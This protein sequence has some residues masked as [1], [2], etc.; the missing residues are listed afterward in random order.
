MLAVR[1]DELD[2]EFGQLRVK[3]GGGDNGH[4][5]LRSIRR[6]IGSGEFFRVRFG[7]GRPPGRQEPVFLSSTTH[8]SPMRPRNLQLRLKHY[9]SIAGLDPGL[10]PHKLLHSYATHL[11]DGG[12][13]L[14]SV[15]TM[16][17]HADI[18]IAARQIESMRGLGRKQMAARVA[19]LSGASLHRV[20]QRRADAAKAR[21]RRDVIHH[22]LAVILD[23]P[24]R[25]HHLILDRH[26]E[27]RA[28][29]GD[30]HFQI[31]GRLVGEPPPEDLAV[32]AMIERKEFSN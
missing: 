29:I 17:G 31:F 30:Q 6:S 7:V 19:A 10:T 18:S 8:P 23:G 13:D 14:R 2:V 12:A 15:Q 27:R 4:N 20:Q 16:L 24:D 3:F 9:L 26:Q 21:V 28:G 32:V 22:D 11:L 5:G 25:E 1:H